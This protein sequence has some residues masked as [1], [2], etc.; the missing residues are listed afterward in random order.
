MMPT[1]RIRGAVLLGMLGL[2]AFLSSASKPA[3]G[4]EKSEEAVRLGDET[5]LECHMQLA[6]AWHSHR[7][8]RYVSAERQPLEVRGCE[9]CHGPGSKHLEDENFRSI[10][11]PNNLTG[12]AAA[13]ACLQC[14]APQ[15]PPTRW[16]ATPHAQAGMNCG[17]CHQVHID[18]QGPYMLRKQVNQLCLTCHPEEQAKFKLNS[19]HPVT[20]GRLECV[21]CHNPHGESPV[22]TELLRNGNDKCVRCHLDKKGPF[23]FEHLTATGDKGEDCL[24]CHSSHGSPNQKLLNFAG[25][26][27][28]LQCHADI[29]ADGPHRARGGNCWQAGCH[30]QFHGSNRSRLYIN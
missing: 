25:R 26:A 16:L 12:M 19:H 13:E 4:D 24:A 15:I 22:G 28:C 17:T 30:N 9:G 11:N 6:K 2:T 8:G 3:Q 1:G 14:H 7:H 27:N 20:E 23:V 5:C 21:S 29:A 10:R 18:A